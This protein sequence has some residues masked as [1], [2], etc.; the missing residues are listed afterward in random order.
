MRV[1]RHKEEKDPTNVDYN[2]DFLNNSEKSESQLKE[3]LF[4]LL[5]RSKLNFGLILDI[6]DFES[7]VDIKSTLED[8][9]SVIYSSKAVDDCCGSEDI[10]NLFKSLGKDVHVEDG[11]A[12]FTEVPLEERVET[13]LRES[14]GDY[15][16]D[17]KFVA[18][19]EGNTEVYESIPNGAKDSDYSPYD[20]SSLCDKLATIKYENFSLKLKLKGEY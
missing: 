3:E 11:V 2:K 7:L 15:I 9:D 8:M 13:V 14:Y 18:Y 12:T 19:I 20:F 17:I 16:D 5:N 6:F 4:R 1:F 10:Y